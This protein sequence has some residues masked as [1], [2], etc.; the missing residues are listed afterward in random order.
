MPH[1]TECVKRKERSTK[2]PYFAGTA[3]AK[4]C[5]YFISFLIENSVK[6]L[7]LATQMLAAQMV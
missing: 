1:T 5:C 6:A 7:K 2:L 4:V 3:S